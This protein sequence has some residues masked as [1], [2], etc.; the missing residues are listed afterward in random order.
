[1]NFE[2]LAIHH[3]PS[4]GI[5]FKES[6]NI[7]FNNNLVYGNTWWTTS[8]TSGVALSECKG[9]G[10]ISIENNIVYANRNF[11]P[12]YKNSVTVNF[13]EGI[14]NYGTYSQ[15]RIIDGQGIYTTRTADYEGTFI[16]KN[17]TVFDNGINGIS[18]HKTTNP[19][20]KVHVVNNRVFDNGKT[21]SKWE[22]R[23]NAG[24]VVVNSGGHS[25]DAKVR[26]AHNKVVTGDRPDVTYQC[27]GSCSFT[28][29]SKS[30]TAC[31]GMP[32][33]AFKSRIFESDFNCGKQ[34][35]HFQRLKAKY[36]DSKMPNCPQYT[37]F[38]E[39]KGYNCKE[40]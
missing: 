17:N 2:H 30:N 11:M 29:N 39:Q 4:A 10:T 35:S 22:S 7:K 36:P 32:N 18:I 26:L 14:H 37:P 25:I 19:K 40:N 33:K 24:G 15:N 12:F 13:S 20:A 34:Y 9:K 8:A 6:D 31:G 3:C 28:R 1:M 16:V 21:S 27:Y 5:H 23:Q 38:T